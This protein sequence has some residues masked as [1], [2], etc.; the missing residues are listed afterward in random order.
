VKVAFDGEV[1]W[2]TSPLAIRVL[3]KPLW[4][5]KAPHV[6]TSIAADTAS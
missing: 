5:L 2:M 1:S 4:L 6:S 3:P